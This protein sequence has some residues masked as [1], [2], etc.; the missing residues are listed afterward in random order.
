MVV[1]HGCAF[2]WFAGLGPSPAFPANPLPEA[3]EGS[4]ARPR[5]RSNAE[6]GQPGP[7]LLR[8]AKRPSGRGGK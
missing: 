6:D 8:D 1:G 7:I 3:R 4:T 5:G 2:Y